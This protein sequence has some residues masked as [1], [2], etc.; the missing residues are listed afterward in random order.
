VL[1]PGRGG[2]R[3]DWLEQMPAKK[4][5]YGGRHDRKAGTP[6]AH[7]LRFAQVFHRFILRLPSVLR[8]EAGSAFLG[9]KR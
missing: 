7:A 6:D 8:G 4:E 1:A 9:R 2:R 5:H 3:G